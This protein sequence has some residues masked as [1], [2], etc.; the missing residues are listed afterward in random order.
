[1]LNAELSSLSYRGIVVFNLSA[2][3]KENVVKKLKARHQ[4]GCY[5]MSLSDYKKKYKK[6]YST[7]DMSSQL[8]DLVL[9]TVDKAGSIPDTKGLKLNGEPVDQLTVL[10]VLNALQSREVQLPL[11]MS[12]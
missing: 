1:M 7:V 11:L 12:P 9:T 6:L 8:Q 3:R 4:R 10:G 5:A 2:G